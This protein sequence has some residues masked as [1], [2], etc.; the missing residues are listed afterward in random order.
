MNN[1][2]C[3]MV[4]WVVAVSSQTLALERSSSDAEQ[5]QLACPSQDFSAFLN[6]F[7]ERVEVQRAF[8]T[9][10]LQKQHLESGADPE[11]KPVV[12]NLSRSQVSFPVIPAASERKLKQLTLRAEPVGDSAVKLFLVKADTDYQ[13]VYFFN[14]D[15]CWRLDRIEDGSL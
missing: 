14:K 15:A 5:Q 9:Y 7:A 4:A 12:R 3:L 2:R 13:V 6:A 11:P 8:T 1:L 10:P